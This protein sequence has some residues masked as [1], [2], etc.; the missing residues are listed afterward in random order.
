MRF[1]VSTCGV[2]IAGSGS[3]FLLQPVCLGSA[4]GHGSQLQSLVSLSPW[5]QPLAFGS[6]STANFR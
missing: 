3:V 2:C 1:D 6:N 5:L 4:D